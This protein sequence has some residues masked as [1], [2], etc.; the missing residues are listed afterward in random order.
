VLVGTGDLA[1][2]G[3]TGPC[4]AQ[5][6]SRI[7]CMRAWVFSK[8]HLAL[9]LEINIVGSLQYLDGFWLLYPSVILTSGLSLSTL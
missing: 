7:Y 4:G 6:V 8:I 5:R 9:N 2:F 1:Y 3:C